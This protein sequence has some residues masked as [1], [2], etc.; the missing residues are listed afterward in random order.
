MTILRGTGLERSTRLKKRLAAA[1]SRRF[2]PV[3]ETLAKLIAPA[4][5][6]LAGHNHAALEEQLLNVAQ[7]Q[8][9]A[10]VPAHGATDDAG[11]ETVTVI[12]RFRFLHR[13]IL[14]DRSRNLTMPKP[15]I[16][17]LQEN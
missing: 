1:L 15:H 3:S 17:R 16:F 2:D 10:E 14:R 7:A 4:S 6:R 12:A 9:E 13:A 11:W 5:D 8:L